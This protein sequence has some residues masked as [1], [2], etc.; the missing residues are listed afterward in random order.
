[1]KMF[2]QCWEVVR[3]ELPPKLAKVEYFMLAKERRTLGDETHIITIFMTKETA[4][5]LSRAGILDSPVYPY[6]YQFKY[7]PKT[8]NIKYLRTT[9]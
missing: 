5:H 4:F 6:H 3:K 8:G 1:M 7:D 2:Q 9:V